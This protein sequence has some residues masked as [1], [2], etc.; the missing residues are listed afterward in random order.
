VAVATDRAHQPAVCSNRGACDF[1]TGKCTCDVGFTGPACSR[2][3]L[4][5]LLHGI[6][7]R[8]HSTYAFVLA[9]SCPNDCSKQG[10]CRSMRL[11]TSRKDRGFPPSLKYETN[12]DA[13]MVHGCSCNQGYLGGDCSKRAYPRH[14]LV[15]DGALGR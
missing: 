3:E 6:G 15:S 2:C 13:D 14:G 8:Q 1:T 10:E 4:L 5:C 9:V 7:S 12:W 11:H